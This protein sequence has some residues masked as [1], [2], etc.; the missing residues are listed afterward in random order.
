MPREGLSLAALRQFARAC[1]GKTY[2]P[3]SG[4]P[5]V[6]FEQL[7]TDQVCTVAVKTATLSGGRDGSHCSYADILLAQVRARGRVLRRPAPGLRAGREARAR[8]R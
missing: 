4:A 3:E 5:P 7:T 6:P 8:E 1:A 2:T